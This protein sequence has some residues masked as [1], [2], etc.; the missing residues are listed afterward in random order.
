MIQ[1]VEGADHIK[2]PGGKE[3]SMK[4]VIDDGGLYRLR[5]LFNRPNTRFD[6]RDGVQMTPSHFV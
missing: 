2:S 6:S 5:G 4:D 1:D 3:A